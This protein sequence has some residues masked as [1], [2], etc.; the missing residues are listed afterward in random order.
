MQDKK[1]KTQ[2]LLSFSALSMEPNDLLPC[3]MQLWRRRCTYLQGTRPAFEPTYIN[4]SRGVMGP[5]VNCNPHK[6]TFLYPFLMQIRG[7]QCRLFHID[8]TLLASGLQL[9]FN[10]SYIRQYLA[11]GCYNLTHL[12]WIFR[13]LSKNINTYMYID[14]IEK[15]VHALHTVIPNGIF[16]LKGLK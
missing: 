8:I 2:L 9:F 15:R 14:K 16:L 4:M 12:M 6:P 13:I 10:F 5:T 3:N 11:K 7:L 1:L